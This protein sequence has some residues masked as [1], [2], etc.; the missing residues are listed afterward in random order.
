M[1]S[2]RRNKAVSADDDLYDYEDAQYEEQE[3]SL[4]LT[5]QDREQLRQ[6]SVQVRQALGSESPLVTEDEIQEAL[7]HYYYDVGKSVSYL[8]SQF[9]PFNQSCYRAYLVPI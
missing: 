6:G 8:K 7:W 4:G 2:H 5:D 1:A 9:C 3:E